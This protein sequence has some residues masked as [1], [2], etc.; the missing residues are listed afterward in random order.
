MFFFLRVARD[1]RLLVYL[2]ALKYLLNLH[3]IIW[4]TFY[5]FFSINREKLTLGSF[6]LLECLGL[7]MQT[8]L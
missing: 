1:N 2:V 7:L 8:R 4:I 3:L 6:V 5:I